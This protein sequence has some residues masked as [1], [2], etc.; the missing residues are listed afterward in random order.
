M[1]D[2]TAIEQGNQLIKKMLNEVSKE[3]KRLFLAAAEELV[4]QH[5]GSREGKVLELAV[6]DV[7]G[8]NI[9]WLEESLQDS[10]SETISQLQM[11]IE[12]LIDERDAAMAEIERLESALAASGDGK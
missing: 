12:G 5:Y 8:T 4:C 11:L 6:E 9:E 10:A 2:E 7:K 3:S 1:A